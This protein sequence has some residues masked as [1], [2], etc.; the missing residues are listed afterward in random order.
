MFNRYLAIELRRRSPID[1]RL[2]SVADV[3][4]LEPGG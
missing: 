4:T 1:E 2:E 3:V